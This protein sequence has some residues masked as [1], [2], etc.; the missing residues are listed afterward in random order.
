MQSESINFDDTATA[1]AHRS[2]SELKNSHFVFTTM[3]KPW[4]VKTGTVMTNLALKLKLPVKGIIKKTIF[5]Q[6][7]GGESI[8]DCSD[9]INRLGDHN[10][11]TI[12]DYSVEGLKNEDGYDD[13]KEEALRVIDFAS[14][15]DHIPFCVLK[16]S[17]LGSTDLMTKAQNK[18]QLTEIEKTKL[19]NCEQRVDEI[20]HKASGKGLMVMIDAE[21]SWFQSFIDGVAYR[22]MAK[23]NKERPIV[24]NTYQMYRH[25]MLDRLTRAQIEAEVNGYYLGAKLV[26]GAYM[27]KE[28][29]RAEELGYESPIH[30]NKEAVDKDYDEA[31]KFCMLHIDRMGLCAGTHNEDSSKLLAELMEEQEIARK[32]NRIFFAQL[33]GMSD[34]ISFKLADLGYNVAKYVPYGPVEKVLPYLFRR[35]EENTS[36]AGQSGREYTLVKKELKRRNSA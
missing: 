14:T 19:Y 29:E 6:F 23:Y 9:T 18:E 26:R 13:T 17:G 24:Y 12:L 21:E 30:A 11:Q 16:L 7:C 20:V 15:N 2:T 1:F 27:E 33:L 35:A 36:I 5:N 31:L 32:D 28:R 3:S 34:N 22:M 4:M 25:D 8:K 10:V